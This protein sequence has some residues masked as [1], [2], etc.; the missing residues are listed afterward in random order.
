M[1]YLKQTKSD[2]K[3][4]WWLSEAERKYDG[5]LVFNKYRDSNLQDEKSYKDG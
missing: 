3:R 2:T 5:E 4:E 1:R